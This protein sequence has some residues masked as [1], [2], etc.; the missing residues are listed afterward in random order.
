VFELAH[1]AI[2]ERMQLEGVVKVPVFRLRTP[3]LPVPGSRLD[4]CFYFVVSDGLGLSKSLQYKENLNRKPGTGNRKPGIRVG[5]LEHSCDTLELHALPKGE[6]RELG[7][8][9]DIPI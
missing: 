2:R 1:L 5:Q 3:G 4:F 7:D 8:F 9:C 6:V